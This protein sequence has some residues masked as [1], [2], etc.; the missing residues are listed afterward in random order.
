MNHH[1]LQF[2]AEKLAEIKNISKEN[3]VKQLQNLI[4]LF[5]N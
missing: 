2:T 5:F 1:L 4:N 3:L